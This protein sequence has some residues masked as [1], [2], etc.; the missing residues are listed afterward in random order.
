MYQHWSESLADALEIYKDALERN[1]WAVY[2]GDA[3]NKALRVAKG[4][5][6]R[7]LI[8]GQES[9]SGSTLRGEARRWGAQ[10]ARSRDAVLERIQD[11]TDVSV[12]EIRRPRGGRRVLVL[13]DSDE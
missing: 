2:T 7:A 8:C 13:V 6:Q 11:Q 4:A 12:Y 9:L 1:T 3:R 10:Y 5:Y